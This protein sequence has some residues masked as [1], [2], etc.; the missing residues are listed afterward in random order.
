MRLIHLGW[1]ITLI[2]SAQAIMEGP[3]HPRIS[4]P[5][6]GPASPEKLAMERNG[7]LKGPKVFLPNPGFEL[8]MGKPWK[9]VGRGVE[10]VDDISL[11]RKGRNSL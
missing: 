10:V 3:S 7:T 5:P 9:L 1:V 4:Y 2:T 8:N 6:D 11:S